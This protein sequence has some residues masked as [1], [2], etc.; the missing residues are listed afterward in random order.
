MET[1]M[2]PS[3]KLALALVGQLASP[4]QSAWMM[5]HFTRAL[6]CLGVTNLCADPPLTVLYNQRE[7]L[8]QQAREAGLRPQ[9]RFVPLLEEERT[10]KIQE[11]QGDESLAGEEAHDTAPTISSRSSESR[12][13]DGEL[14]VESWWS[15]WSPARRCFLS[16]VWVE[17]EQAKSSPLLQVC[18]L[19]GTL[20][21]LDALLEAGR[22][23]ALW[24]AGS[25]S[26][27]VGAECQSTKLPPNVG[28]SI[29]PS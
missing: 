15:V 16:Q 18:E 5:S 6:R 11:V 21:E 12:A 22:P 13:G 25:P 20:L 4:M 26:I 1:P 17:V 14:D 28:S 29:R 27:G 3:P 7:E 23:V 2:G 9:H 10:K 8:L 24:T 19:D